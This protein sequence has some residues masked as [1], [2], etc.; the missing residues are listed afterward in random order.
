MHY[1]CTDNPWLSTTLL[2]CQCKWT[3]LL[4]SYLVQT[5]PW[6]T[7]NLVGGYW[8]CQICNV[9]ADTDI[10]ILC[11]HGLLPVPVW[12]SNRY[13]KALFD[14]T[15]IWNRQT[16]SRFESVLTVGFAFTTGLVFNKM[17]GWWWFTFFSSY[18]DP[19]SWPL[20]GWAAM[21]PSRMSIST[22]WHKDNKDSF[23]GPQEFVVGYS[24]APEQPHSSA[25]PTCHSHAMTRMG[26]EPATIRIAA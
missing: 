16:S 9:C 14:Y 18:F 19:V 22:M 6:D 13:S 11:G 7:K 12:W 23:I 20:I 17:D 5:C 21:C 1:N 8:H 4:A 26:R 25:R 24:K 10:Y 2:K 3:F 15:W